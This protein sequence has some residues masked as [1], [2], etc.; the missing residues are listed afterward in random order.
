MELVIVRPPL[1]Y[2]PG[3]QANFRALVRAAALGWPLPLGAV[4]NLRSFVALDNLVD[5]LV[6]CGTHPAAAHQAF[7][8]SDGCDLSTT[9]LLQ[10]LAHAQGPAGP[11][12]AVACAAAAVVGPPERAQRG[13]AAPVRQPATRHFQDPH[14]ARMGPAG[15]RG[16][17]FS[18]PR[19]RVRA[20]SGAHP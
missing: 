19:G 20:R 11:L 14:G 16:R 7:L 1:V 13:G 10:R 3:V 8:V 9:A 4:H 2:G 6:V 5:L 18:P 15:E 12:V 17:G